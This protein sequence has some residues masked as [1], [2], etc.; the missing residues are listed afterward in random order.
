MNGNK[1]TGDIFGQQKYKYEIRNG[2]VNS[3]FRYLYSTNQADNNH[4]EM[5]V[6]NF[7]SKLGN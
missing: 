3:S 4:Y 5:H 2:A 1:I 7:I 6:Y